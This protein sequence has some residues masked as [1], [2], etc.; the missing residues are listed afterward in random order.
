MHGP[1]QQHQMAWK[2]TVENRA[3]WKQLFPLIRIK[4]L[5]ILAK[6]TFWRKKAYRYQSLQ[7]RDAF[8]KYIHILKHAAN[9]WLRSRKHLKVAVHKRLF[10][11]SD[12][13][14]FLI[15]NFLMTFFS[16][17]LFSC[18]HQSFYAVQYKDWTVLFCR[19]IFVTVHI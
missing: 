2:N 19:F 13:S 4:P 12:H 5:Q 17:L 8:I 11:G 10:W 18:L 9:L 7:S 6:T 14:S 3:S 16:W 15:T 1:A